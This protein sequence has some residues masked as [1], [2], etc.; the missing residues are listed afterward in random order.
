M[1]DF[2][3]HMFALRKTGTSSLPDKMKVS[4]PAW[5]D[6]ERCILAA[7]EFGGSVSFDLEKEIGNGKLSNLSM[8]SS[9]GNF[10]LMATIF[11][12]KKDKVI[13]WQEPED[14][15]DRGKIEIAG[16]DWDARWVQTDVQLAL[17]IFQEAFESGELSNH[18][19]AHMR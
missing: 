3:I 11:G 13:S 17:G 9:P 12:E 14:S 2:R 7:H 16:D 10:L 4:D 5:A 19:L 15:L 1:S 8:R 18:S 6:V